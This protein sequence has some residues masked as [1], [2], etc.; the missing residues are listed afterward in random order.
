M[1]RVVCRF[2][3][4]SDFLRQFRWEQA[5]GS[6]CRALMDEAADFMF[7]GE[8]KLEPGEHIRLTA[9]VSSHREQCHLNMTVIDV[10]PMASE[11]GRVFR[12]RARIA[13]EDAVWLLSF[14]QKMTTRRWLEEIAA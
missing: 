4:E 1:R 10:A 7:V 6:P 2:E 14:R 3:D 9:L 11:S 5:V 13:P 8:F 12:Y